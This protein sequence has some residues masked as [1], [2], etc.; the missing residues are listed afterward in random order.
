MFILLSSASMYIC[1][2]GQES[3]ACEKA[4]WGGGKYSV[5]LS[6]YG[7]IKFRAALG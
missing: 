2:L 1:V 6:A 4:R 3:G 5:M 7:L